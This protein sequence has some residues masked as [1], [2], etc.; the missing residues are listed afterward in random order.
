MQTIRCAVLLLVSCLVSTTA[1]AQQHE[2][3][4]PGKEHEKLKGM[5]GKWDATV[6]GRDG[7]EHKGMITYTMDLGGMWL[8]SDFECDMGGQK[9]HG[10]GMDGYDTFKKKY[11]GAWYD[12]MSTAPMNFEGDLD[13]SGKLLTMHGEGRDHTGQLK[14]HKLVTE[15]K[16]KDRMT[17][18]MYEVDP[19]GKAREVMT[20]DY[21]RRN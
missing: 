19:D 6:K 1:L 9:Y 21:K 18:T 5:E 3:P 13:A 8:V 11:V 16:D 12:S 10:H 2:Y 20:I 7:K 4:K 15:M 14:K 17:F